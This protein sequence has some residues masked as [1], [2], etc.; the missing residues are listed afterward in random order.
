MGVFSRKLGQE[1]RRFAVKLPGEAAQAFGRKITSSVQHHG[2]QVSDFA[3]G[4]AEKL[5]GFEGVSNV[6]HNVGSGADSAVSVA[7]LLDQNQPR[8]AADTFL[9]AISKYY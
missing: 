8:A 1:I 7:R 4:A 5:K 6:L 3:H 9:Q 2:Q